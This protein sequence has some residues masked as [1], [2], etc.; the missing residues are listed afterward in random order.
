MT[1]LL[2]IEVVIARGQHLGEEQVVRVS[3]RLNFVEIK[4]AEDFQ[5]HFES[6]LVE[7]CREFF[8]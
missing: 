5:L 4:W 8:P 7:H 3:D 2:N 1:E 6:H